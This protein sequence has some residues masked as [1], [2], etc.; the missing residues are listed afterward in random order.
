MTSSQKEK[1][2]KLA[3]NLIGKSYKYGVSQEEAPNF[4]DCSSFTQYVL[5]Q[6]GIELPRSSILQAADLKGEEINPLPDLSNLKIGDLLFMRSDRGH[7]YDR[8][9]GGREVYIGHVGI[10]IGNGEVIHSREEKIDGV[11]IEKLDELTK[12]PNYHIAI[13]KRF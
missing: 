6:I 8:L 1:L 9:F 11:G 10:Y 12:N 7:Y 4:F 5:K 13:I 3:R 2:V